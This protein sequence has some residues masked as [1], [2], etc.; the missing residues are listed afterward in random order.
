MK[1]RNCESRKTGSERTSLGD[2]AGAI[3]GGK[4]PFPIIRL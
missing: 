4:H 2:T 1:Y 3:S